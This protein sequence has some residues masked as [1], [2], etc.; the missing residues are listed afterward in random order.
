MFQVAISQ[1]EEG[2][3]GGERKD[4]DSRGKGITTLIQFLF[5]FILF[6]KLNADKI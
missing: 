4:R 6:Y 2:G 3:G 1:E 5:Y